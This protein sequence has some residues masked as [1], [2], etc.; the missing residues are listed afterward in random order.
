MTLS[1]GFNR[2]AYFNMLFAFWVI[3]IVGQK[4]LVETARTFANERNCQCTLFVELAAEKPYGR[5]AYFY[6]AI[7]M[8]FAT[9]N[10][11]DE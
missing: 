1:L 11:Y 4:H 8:R 7:G 5:P 6:E 2:A 3:K 10:Q 9:L